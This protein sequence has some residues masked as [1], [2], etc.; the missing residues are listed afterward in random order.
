MT[1][2]QQSVKT[3]TGNQSI[4]EGFLAWAKERGYWEVLRFYDNYVAFMKSKQE[5]E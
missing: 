1:T 4:L 2:D 5:Q 3:E